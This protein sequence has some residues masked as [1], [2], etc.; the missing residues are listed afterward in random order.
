MRRAG[1]SQPWFIFAAAAVLA[2]ACNSPVIDAEASHAALAYR[3]R[4]PAA[5]RSHR[6][7]PDAVDE[8]GCLSCFTAVEPLTAAAFTAV[9]AVG[10]LCYKMIAD[11]AASVHPEN[12]AHAFNWIIEDFVGGSQPYQL[13]RL[14]HEQY[15]LRLC[16]KPSPTVTAAMIGAFQS[17]SSD[18][19]GSVIKIEVKATQSANDY[20]RIYS[21]KLK[22]MLIKETCV[23]LVYPDQIRIG[24][25]PL[26]PKC[27]N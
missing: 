8:V 5:F 6:F 20:S 17:C 4:H 13:D 19:P 12:S 10:T 1:A 14:P 27:P 25:I 2:V 22:T 7:R 15:C 3:Q 21:G 24:T 18:H 26:N 23:W 16:K 11:A 9:S